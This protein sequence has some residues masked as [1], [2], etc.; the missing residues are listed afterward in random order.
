MAALAHAPST[1]KFLKGLV[2]DRSVGLGFRALYSVTWVAADGS[3]DLD[4]FRFS[5]VLRPFSL[6]HSLGFQPNS[7]SLLLV[8]RYFYQPTE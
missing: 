3:L 1:S 6:Y 4:Q 7:Q 5:L 2:G 8:F